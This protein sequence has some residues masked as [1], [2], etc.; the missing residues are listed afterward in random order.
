MPS[1]VLDTTA[2][3]SAFL[4]AT[5][6][7]AAFELLQF[8]SAGRYE[9]ILSDP[10]LV[11]VADVL[12]NRAHLRRRYLYPDRAV[13]AYVTGLRAT[14][15]LVSDL[16]NLNVV[17]DPT[18]NVILATAVAGAADFLCT[19]DNDL[20]DLKRHGNVTILRPEDLLARLR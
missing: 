7:G 18:D 14:A 13:A 11:E 12:L 3:V 4:T 16:P 6:G 1:A 17:R 5:P 10:I 8:A 20:L 19:R 9:L 2:L 15:S